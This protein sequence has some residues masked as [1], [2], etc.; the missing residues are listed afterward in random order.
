MVR[1]PIETGVPEKKREWLKEGLTQRVAD[2]T[3]EEER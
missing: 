3:T 1:M 2:T